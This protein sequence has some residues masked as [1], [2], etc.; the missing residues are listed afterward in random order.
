MLEE[1][2]I[3]VLRGRRGNR[4]SERIHIVGRRDMFQAEKGISPMTP[5]SWFEVR[6]PDRPERLVGGRFRF[7][8][9]GLTVIELLIVI[10]IIGLLAALL[11]PAVQ[12]AR[13]TSRRMA[14]GSNLKQIGLAIANY[15]SL[16]GMFPPGSSWGKSLFVNLL[17]HMER[18]DLAQRVDYADDH[19]ADFLQGVLIPTY[20]CPSDSVPRLITSGGTPTAGTNY[21]ASSGVWANDGGFNGL[22]RTLADFWPYDSGPIRAADVTDGLSQTTAVA[23]ILRSDESGRRLR[24]AW[25]LPQAL[26]TG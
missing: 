6:C 10:V 7:P 26:R 14:C 3:L 18:G 23:E 24:A 13:E 15:E 17:A 19:G 20:V 8:R 4:Q 2:K 5:S 22:F 11:I 16:H 12:S 9:A 21:A 1:L 25:Y